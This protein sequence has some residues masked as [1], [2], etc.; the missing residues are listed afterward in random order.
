ML[1][2]KEIKKIMEKPGQVRGAVFN[3]DAKYILE[4][5][6]EEGLKKVEE[7]TREWGQPI[8]Y[9]KTKNMGWYPVGLR[10]VSLLAAEEV[11]NWRDE[12]I[13]DMGYSAP[14][15]SF[16]VK[17]LMKY[18]LTLEQTYKKSPSYWAEHY[19]IGELR[20]P[21]YNEKGKYLVLQIFN[22]ELHPILCSYYVGYFRKIAELGSRQEITDIEKT[23][24]SFRGDSC[25]E[26]VIKW[27]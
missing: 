21:E 22:F 5:K 8:D 13:E 24:C 23:K 16:I 4:K 27:K 18:L 9:K 26:Y 6:G 1:T 11:F 12:E 7:K 17:L 2:P 25:H 10:A 3:T 14:T 15:H 19:D 20:V